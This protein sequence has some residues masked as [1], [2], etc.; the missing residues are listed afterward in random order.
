MK[1]RINIKIVV[2][3]LAAVAF[4]GLTAL[5][6]LNHRLIPD[7]IAFWRLTPDE[8]A[9]KYI[10]DRIDELGEDV[11]GF[12]T[13][14]NWFL[15]ER[16]GEFVEAQVHKVIKWEYTKAR[17]LDVEDMY[18]VVATA[19]VGFSVDTPLGSGS[20]ESGL[21]FVL[22]ID[23]ENQRVVQASKDFKSAYIDTDLPDLPSLD[24]ATDKAK[25]A[26]D[27][28]VDSAMDAVDKTADS[29]MDVVDKTVDTAKNVVD[30]ESIDKAKDVVEETVDSVKG[31]I[32]T[33]SID[34]AKDAVKEDLSH[35]NCL[36][37]ARDAGVPERVLGIIQK[38]SDERSGIER[39][40][41]RRGLDAV[42]LSETC[43]DLE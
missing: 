17:P 14:G 10:N 9:V 15:R 20:V 37:A 36:D 11:A 40:V 19:K 21:P 6:A 31:A 7:A 24:A 30:V 13:G 22:T 33:E 42:G 29:A 18:E 2:I 27:K 38:P 35:E 28:T 8:L 26:V 41:L 23:H 34:K 43:T 16:G 1:K 5:T 39:S 4:V 32:D 3:V 12:I 25:E